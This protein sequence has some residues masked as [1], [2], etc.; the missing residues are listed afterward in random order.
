MQQHTGP[1]ATTAA[2]PDRAVPQVSSRRHHRGATTLPP[3]SALAAAAA[4]AAHANGPCDT[5]FLTRGIQQGSLGHRP[6]PAP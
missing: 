6:P 1:T 3:W 2:S 4:D 5:R